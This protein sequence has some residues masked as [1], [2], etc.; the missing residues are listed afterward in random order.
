MKLDPDSW[1]YKRRIERMKKTY[2][3]FCKDCEKEYTLSEP[4]IH[5]CSDSPK[6]TARYYDLRKKAAKAKEITTKPSAQ[7][8]LYYQECDRNHG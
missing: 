8:D 4:C 2:K 6:D 1:E 5:H 7:K 3:L